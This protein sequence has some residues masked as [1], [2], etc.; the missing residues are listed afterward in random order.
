MPFVPRIRPAFPCWFSLVFAAAL[1]G[2]GSESVSKPADAT[3]PGLD[4]AEPDVAVDS[5]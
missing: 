4:A 3:I 1:P 2:C 5:P